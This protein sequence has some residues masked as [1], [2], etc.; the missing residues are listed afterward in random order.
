MQNSVHTSPAYNLMP[1]RIVG[2]IP[3][4]GATS[5]QSDPFLHVK[6]FMPDGGWTWFVAEFDPASGIAFGYVIGIESE[7]GSFSLQEVQ[8][9]R[10]ALGLPVERDLHFDPCLSS[11]I[12]K[13]HY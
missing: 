7:W 1:D 2:T 9:V 5:E 3:P 6:W 12:T 8:Q 4:I 11:K 10:G 13:S